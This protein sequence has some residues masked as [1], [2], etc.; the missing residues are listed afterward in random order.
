MEQPT[1]QQIGRGETIKTDHSTWRQ[2]ITFRTRVRNGTHDLLYLVDGRRS[3][4]QGFSQQHLPQDTAET[5]HVNAF[6]VPFDRVMETRLENLTIV[7]LLSSYRSWRIL[8][9]HSV[10]CGSQQNLWRSV[11]ARG[12]VL[13][14]RW[15]PTVL[16]DLVQ[17]S[18]QAE[19][20]Q[21]D[22]AVGVQQHVGRLKGRTETETTVG[23]V[24]GR[25]GTCRPI[26]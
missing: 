19:V 2:V 3:R 1:F 12:H 22:H 23:A 16:L 26:S 20:A 14:Q 8:K 11:P 7:D 4:E 17:R 13:R 18:G 25:G 24:G 21:L 6:G 5:P 9:F 15:I 10:P